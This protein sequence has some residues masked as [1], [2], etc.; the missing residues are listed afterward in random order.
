MLE[1]L[2][3]H[4]LRV[5]SSRCR[6]PTARQNGNKPAALLHAQPT[7]IALQHELPCCCLHPSQSLGMKTQKAVKALIQHQRAF[8]H[9]QPGGPFGERSGVQM[10]LIV[11]GEGERGSELVLL[12]GAWDW[13]S[14]STSPSTRLG[15]SWLT[16]TCSCMEL[17]LSGHSGCAWAG[18]HCNDAP[19]QSSSVSVVSGRLR[20]ASS[21]QPGEMRASTW[22]NTFTPSLVLYGRLSSEPQRFVLPSSSALMEAHSEPSLYAL[23]LLRGRGLGSPRKE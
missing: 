11:S 21:A 23:A 19:S 20:S 1:I 18:L 10:G 22:I 17:L 12:P 8:I 2:C 16:L 4:T 7:A 5:H 13:S 3:Y 9:S 6:H 15:S 14:D